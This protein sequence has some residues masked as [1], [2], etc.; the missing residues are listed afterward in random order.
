M[1]NNEDVPG[2]RRKGSD[3]WAG[4]SN[5]YY[6][7]DPTAGKLGVAFTSLSPFLDQEVLGLFDTLREV[8]AL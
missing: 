3:A 7:V 4:I 8:Y 5:L 1:V 6:L 2:G